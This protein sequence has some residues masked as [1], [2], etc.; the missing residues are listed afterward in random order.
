MVPGQQMCT[1]SSNVTQQ[2]THKRIQ[3][4]NNLPTG[5][6][7]MRRIIIT[8]IRW[9]FGEMATQ[10]TLLLGNIYVGHFEKMVA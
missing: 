6:V 4:V 5:S 3:T 2:A 9:G 10:L 8:I 7:Y 1:L